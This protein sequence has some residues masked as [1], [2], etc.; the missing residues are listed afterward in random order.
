MIVVPFALLLLMAA[1]T[2]GCSDSTNP[3]SAQKP[4]LT[5]AEL[6]LDP[7]AIRTSDGQ[8]VISGTTNLPDGLKMSIEVERGRLPLGAPKAVASDDAVIVKDGK[9]ASAPLWLQVPNTRFTKSG[10]PRGVSVDMRDVPFP[11]GKFKVHLSSYFNGAWQTPEVLSAIG[12][13]D[14]KRLKGKILTATDPDVIDS[15]K[16][17]DYRLTLP[18][19]AITPSAVAVNLVRGAILTVPGEGRSAGDVQANIDLYMISPGLGTAEGWMATTKG[20]GVFDVSY[21]FVD[22]NKGRQ[23]AIW[24]VNTSTGQVKYLNEYAKLFSWTPNY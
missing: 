19:P 18:F 15:P 14:G 20:R 2:A 12:G 6:T 9:F 1:A 11:Q 5:S 21:G 23:Q 7:Q 13:E 16:I 4:Y 17:V 24:T 3:I 8:V 10:W 22:G